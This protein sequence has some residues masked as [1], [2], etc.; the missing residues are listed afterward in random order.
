MNHTV[1]PFVNL[2]FHFG[3]VSSL[4]V[5]EKHNGGYRT[6][7][8]LPRPNNNSVN[9]YIDKLSCS[10]TFCSIDD[11]VR[12]L[13]EAGRG[14]IMGKLDLKHAF[15]LIPVRREEWHLLCYKVG[16]SLYC[17]IVWPSGCRSSPRIFVTLPT[18]YTGFYHILTGCD[19]I[20][21]Y[22][23]NYFFAG[24]SDSPQ[25]QMLM[26][27]MVRVCDLLGVPLSP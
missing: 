27:F 8:D 20:L 15:R 17:D 1:G 26:D 5:V 23:D 4:G 14:A 18:R 21:H 19:R 24:V 10:L 22:I 6:V 11:A 25:C 9:S 7:M 3:T 16:L 13:T 2:P 12:L